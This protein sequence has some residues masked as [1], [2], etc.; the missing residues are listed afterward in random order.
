MAA[1]QAVANVSVGSPGGNRAAGSL[2]R[3]RGAAAV[4][5]GGSWRKSSFLSGRMAVGPRRSRPV[6]RNLVASP[7]QMNLSFG[8]TM[9]WWEKG[10][11]PNMRAIQ[12]AQ[13]LVESLIDAGDGLVIVDFF[14]PG[15]AGCHALHPKI[16]QFAER[17]PDVQFLQQL[18][19]AYGSGDS[20]MQIKKFKDA[21]AKHKPDRCSIGPTKGLEESELFALASNKDL[22]F[23]CTR[24]PEL[25]PGI[26]DAAEVITRD[27]PKLPT[28]TNPLVRQGSDDRTL[29]SSGR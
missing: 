24:E 12:T 26:D 20:C 28:P 2:G 9:K 13:D 10:L 17:N 18:M 1:A 27:R 7:V 3:R 15:C 6:S 22:Q 21:L 5:L 11:Q 25:A 29:V 4:R 8:K 23:T 14:S 16:C 19:C